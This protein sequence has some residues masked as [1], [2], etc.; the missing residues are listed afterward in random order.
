MPNPQELKARWDAW[1]AD[2]P[3]Q[4]QKMIKDY[5]PGEYIMTDDAPYGLS[6]PGTKVILESYNEDGML[7][8]IVTAGNKL[9]AGLDHEEM[10][11]I[12]HN[13]IHNLD[14]IHASDVKV[15]VDPQYVKIHEVY[16]MA[17]E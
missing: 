4:I 9:Q 1:V 7:G 8:V 2:R 11:A 10:L 3:E 12:K 17:W 6:C 5:P 13:K 16:K 14:R 15:H